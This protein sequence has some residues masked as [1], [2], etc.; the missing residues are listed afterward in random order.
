MPLKVEKIIRESLSKEND[1]LR[2]TESENKKV[3]KLL[4]SLWFYIYNNQITDESVINLNCY[5]SINNKRLDKFK[6]TIKQKIYRYKYFLGMLEK[7]DLIDVNKKYSS[8]RFCKSYRILTSVLNGNFEEAEIDYKKV[9]HNLKNQKYWLQKYPNHNKQIKDSYKVSIDL[10]KY[11]R[12]LKKNIGIELKP[13]IKNGMVIKRELNEERIFE[14]LNSVLKINYKNLWFKISDEG[15]FYS[16]LTNMSYT[17]L[18]FTKLGGKE[19]REVDVKNCQPLF[20]SSLIDNP[21]YRKDVEDGVFYDVMAREL[22]KTR[23]Q[24]KVLSYQFIFF[25]NRNLSSGKIYDSLNKLYPNFVNQ[26]N[27]LRKE[28]H[29]SKKLQQ[30]ESKILVD[31]IGTLDFEMMLRHDAVF[32]HDEDYEIVCNHVREEFAKLDLKVQIK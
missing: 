10:T 28:I 22:G 19:I 32:V 23:N 3:Y 30:L 6:V 11:Y 18:Q 29:I 5:T 12:W 21:S 15:R 9:F 16:S 27:E 4:I 17:T 13:I 26:I 1:F 8:G 2:N 20:L 7:A 25:S 24:F 31:K 14:Y